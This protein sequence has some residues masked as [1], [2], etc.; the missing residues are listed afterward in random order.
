MKLG[1]RNK[2]SPL[3]HRDTGTA[4]DDL[5]N[6]EHSKAH[7]LKDKPDFKTREEEN[8]FREFVFRS[9]PKYSIDFEFDRKNVDNPINNPYVT[10]AWKKFGSS[11]QD[12]KKKVKKFTEKEES[13]YSGQDVSEYTVHERTTTEPHRISKTTTGVDIGYQSWE[14]TD[15]FEY[16]FKFGSLYG[17]KGY[18]GGG[19]WIKDSWGVGVE[20]GDFEDEVSQDEFIKRFNSLMGHGRWNTDVPEY[21]KIFTVEA[22]GGWTE[23]K[24]RITNNKTGAEIEILLNTASTRESADFIA[25]ENFPKDHFLSWPEINKRVHKF[26]NGFTPE[27][28]TKQQRQLNPNPLLEY[29]TMYNGKLVTDLS[30]YKAILYPQ[31]KQEIVSFDKVDQLNVKETVSNKKKKVN[32]LANNPI[33]QIH[34]FHNYANAWEKDGKWYYNPP[35]FKQS[36][37][38]KPDPE[39]ITNTDVISELNWYQNFPILHK[40]N[41]SHGLYDI[42]FEG[43]DNYLDVQ[44]SINNFFLNSEEDAAGLLNDQLERYGFKAEASNILK[45][46]V[47]ITAPDGKEF[48][49]EHLDELVA[50][51]GTRKQF[52]RWRIMGRR[53]VLVGL[54]NFLHPYLEEIKHDNNGTQDSYAN[55][56]DELTLSSEEENKV[57]KYMWQYQITSIP[58]GEISDEEA[59]ENLEKITKYT[60][61]F[62]NP[63]GKYRYH[64]DAAVNLLESLDITPNEQGE[65]V[66]PV[67]PDNIKELALQFLEYERRD[68]ALQLTSKDFHNKIEGTDDEYKVKNIISKKKTNDVK[69]I[70]KL[71]KDFNAALLDFENDPNWDVFNAFMKVYNGGGVYK[72]PEPSGEKEKWTETYR[73]TIGGFGPFGSVMINGKESM[74]QETGFYKAEID[75]EVEYEGLKQVEIEIAN[76]EKMIVDEEI[77]DKFLIAQELLKKKFNKIKETEKD[78]LYEVGGANES[79]E[80]IKQIMRI[81]NLNYDDWEKTYTNLGLGFA[82][83]WMDFCFG[84]HSVGR[85]LIGQKPDK[86]DVVSKMHIQAEDE[87]QAISNNFQKGIWELDDDFETSLNPGSGKFWSAANR[88]WGWNGIVDQLP[89][90]AGYI[91]PFS[92][93]TMFTVGYGDATSQML[94]EQERTGIEKGFWN[95]TLTAAAYGG[96][97]VILGAFPTKYIMPK[98]LG[99]G[100]MY[101]G[102]KYGLDDLMWNKLM[103]RKWKI[104]GDWRNRM[105]LANNPAFKGLIRLSLK[106][107]LITA[108]PNIFVGRYVEKY[109]EGWTQMLQNVYMGRPVMENVEHAQDMGFLIGG[110]MSDIS[111]TYGMAMNYFSDVNSKNKYNSLLQEKQ[112]LNQ[113]KI[114]LETRIELLEKSKK[115]QKGKNKKKGKYKVQYDNNIKELD[116]AKEDVKTMGELIE[117]LDSEMRENILKAEKKV[118]KIGNKFFKVFQ[119]NFENLQNI[120]LKAEKIINSKLDEKTKEK[121]LTKLKEEFDHHQKFRDLLKDEEVFGDIW[122]AFEASTDK[123][124]VI[125]REELMG[126]VTTKLIEDGNANPSEQEINEAAEEEFYFQEITKDHKNKRRTK[127]GKGFNV[128]Y[129]VEDAIKGYDKLLANG[130]ISEELH[131]ELVEQAKSGEDLGATITLAD[132]GTYAYEIVRNAAK[133]GRSKTRVHEHGHEITIE[134]FGENSTVEKAIAQQLLLF[135]RAKNEALSVLLESRSTRD[136]ELNIFE[137]IPNFM[138]LVAE[139]KID[140]ESKNNFGLGSLIANLFGKGVADA[141]NTDFD[142]D[143]EGEQDATNF[144]IGLAKKINQGK[145]T[146]KERAKIAKNIFSQA[147]LKNQ[148]AELEKATKKD[149][150]KHSKYVGKTPEEL[151]NIIANSDTKPID[152]TSAYSVLLDQYDKIA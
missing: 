145:L 47:T 3:T 46:Q 14:E 83:L 8:E 32:E 86:D 117:N 115:W 127:F 94:R 69:L 61:D 131:A 89:I 101:G 6:E 51:A 11:F 2:K 70:A 98:F 68:E 4:H 100:I 84:A 9:N 76:G 130:Q 18:F 116:Q 60:N 66:D 112:A 110:A 141:S 33:L 77:Y 134:A 104:L 88:E 79:L 133:A 64:Y 96:T 75:E 143:F 31:Y 113:N 22:I 53:E 71:N 103:P 57:L 120:R 55:I 43:K 7:G 102:K 95:Q 25:G 93:G 65:L 35:W 136:G 121:E 54:H 82:D 15:R 73:R 17:S 10:K 147:A 146:L 108:T 142:F 58:F 5:S 139:G 20:E 135:V 78:Y 13:Y 111:F 52:E 118:S 125:R 109:T 138:E 63:S 149:K 44:S 40:S 99:G 16:D 148:I 48:K 50:F 38:P 124:D 23:D 126:E 137:I 80:D 91:S 129:E 37:A 24:V 30:D 132:G 29:N 74:N 34:K 28:I 90:L 49:I 21:R 62:V 72:F 1:I 106:D 123:D 27:V 151:I 85:A 56:K 26:I 128:F 152:I 42:F 119:K 97:E 12:F 122:K 39:Q 81:A 59:E 150:I 144:I 87:I 140:F 45:A 41:E 114:N 105:A 36:G 92:Y 107:Y 67:T 19:K